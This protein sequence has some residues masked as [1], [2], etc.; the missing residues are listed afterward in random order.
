MG[1]YWIFINKTKKVYICPLSFGEGSKLLS[2]LDTGSRTNFTKAIAYLL[3]DSSSN[4]EGGGDIGGQTRLMGSWLGDKVSMIGDYNNLWDN[5]VYKRGKEYLDISSE[6]I[7]ELN[8]NRLMIKKYC[9]LCFE[10]FYTK[11]DGSNDVMH[12][13]HPLRKGAKCCSN[14][15]Q[16]K[17][18]PARM[19]LLDKLS[20]KNKNKKHKKKKTQ[21]SKK[22]KKIKF[23]KVTQ[24]R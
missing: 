9:I 3:T 6:V 18:I 24:S 20:T 2:I 19:K 15:N 13:A 23:K 7:D 16:T 8:K 22:F 17:V 11:K 21:T 14:C 1:Q 4:S 12:N 10:D 5:V